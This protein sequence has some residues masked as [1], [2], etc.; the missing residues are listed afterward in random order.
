MNSE[1]KEKFKTQEELTGWVSKKEAL[2]NKLLAKEEEKTLLTKEIEKEVSEKAI[3]LNEL[4]ENC[5]ILRK[6]VDVV[7]H[8]QKKHFFSLLK[9][10]KD[11]KTEGLY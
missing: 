6:N 10:G 11:T 8:A 1:N 2:K 3:K 7:K 4:D 5:K 9:E